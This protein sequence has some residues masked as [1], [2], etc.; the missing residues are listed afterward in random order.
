MKLVDAV[1]GLVQSFWHDHTRPSSNQK[2]VLKLRRGSKDREPHIKHLLDITQTKLYE[3]FRNE[4]RQLNLGQISF[5]KC[6]PW[7]VRINTLRNTC[8]CRYHVEY[9]YYYETFLYIRRVLHTNHVQD[10]SLTIPPTSSREFIHSIMCNRPEGQTYYAKSCLDGTCSNCAGMEL[11]SQCMHEIGDNEFGNM[12]T[13]MKSF[14]YISYEIVPGKERKKIQLVTSQVHAFIYKIMFEQL[15]FIPYLQ[16]SLILRSFCVN[17]YKLVSSSR[18]LLKRHIN[19]FSMSTWH[20][21]RM[22]IL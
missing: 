21:G 14:K 3:K 20:D 8:C 4:H 18:S 15:H 2:D 12:V 5:E 11:L 16:K 17:R 7:Y 1:K 22:R 10:C 6:K 19:M 9:E 13:D